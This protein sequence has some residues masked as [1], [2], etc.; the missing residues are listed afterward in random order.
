M[1]LEDMAV[2]AHFV[3]ASLPSVSVLMAMFSV[4][5]LQACI[6]EGQRNRLGATGYARASHSGAR[7]DKVS[8]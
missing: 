6:E 1:I 2:V 7:Y 3:S 8:I 4:M 5:N